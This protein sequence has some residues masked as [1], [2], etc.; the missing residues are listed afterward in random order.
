MSPTPLFNFERGECGLAEKMTLPASSQI[1]SDK[2]QAL[3]SFNL[4]FDISMRVAKD[5][6]DPTPTL[7]LNLF[8]LIF[9]EIMTKFPFE[10]ISG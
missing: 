8:L 3:G 5:Q 10:N 1:N 7:V 2:A 4:I 9:P 6:L